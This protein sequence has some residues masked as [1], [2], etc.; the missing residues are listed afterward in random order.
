MEIKKITWRDA[1]S[2]S[3][4]GK[5]WYEKDEALVLAKEKYQLLTFTGGFILENNKNY[6]V[7]ASTK[8]GDDYSDI[9]MIPKKFLL[10]VL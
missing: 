3:I 9:T 8:S 1:A 7:V 2:C 5:V 6:I 10:K 4:D